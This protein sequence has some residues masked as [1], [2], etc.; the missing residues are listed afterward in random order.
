MKLT[1][2]EYEKILARQ[3]KP[4]AAVATQEAIGSQKLV[5]PI[6]PMG[7]PRMTRRDKWAKR[8]AVVAY[9]EYADNIRSACA[10]K[11]PK[12][13]F[14]VSWTAYLPMP[15]SWSQKKKV[16]M[17][18][19]PHRSKPDRDNIDKGILDALFENDSGIS[20]GVL[21]KFWDDGGGSRIELVIQ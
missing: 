18:G 5:I 8:P 3:N 14:S 2:A 4:F 12:D 15:D 7:K 11:I 19:K 10:G 1:S 17:A 13:A 9:R 16:S 20:F 21:K 6:K